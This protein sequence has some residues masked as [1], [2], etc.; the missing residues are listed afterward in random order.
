MQSARRFGK[1][2]L[3]SVSQ[4]DMSPDC[5]RRGDIPKTNSC[6]VGKGDSAVS[7]SSIHRTD[8]VVRV[9]VGAVKYEK[10]RVAMALNE[11]HRNDIR[12]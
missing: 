2:L 1:E 9:M 8:A 3:T 11:G 6:L 4:D 12:G 7:W 10:L 5:D